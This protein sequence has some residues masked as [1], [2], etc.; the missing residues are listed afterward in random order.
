MAKKKNNT[1]LY[2]VGAVALYFIWKKAQ[3]KKKGQVIVDQSTHV[4]FLPTKGRYQDKTTAENMVPYVDPE[5][6]YQARYKESLNS[7][8]Y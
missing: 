1:I 7:C 4:E 5:D 3:D 8:S 2:V 6:Y